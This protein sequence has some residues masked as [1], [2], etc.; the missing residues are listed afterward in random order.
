LTSAYYMSDIV[1]DFWEERLGGRITWFISPL[2]QLE[3]VFE[4]LA[5]KEEE[6]AHEAAVKTQNSKA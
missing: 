5:A 1:R 4:S 2:G 6:A 3:S